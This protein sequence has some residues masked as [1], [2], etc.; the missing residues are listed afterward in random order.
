[1]TVIDR[2]GFD[3]TECIRHR[4]VLPAR[5]GEPV[6]W[7]DFVTSQIAAAFSGITAPWRHQAEAAELAHA[8]IPVIVATGTASGKSLAYLLPAL[9]SIE[10]GSHAPDGRGA[11]VL[12][13]APTK[14]LAHDQ[15]RTLEELKAAGL[16]WLRAATYDGDTPE[17]ERSWVREHANFVLSNPDLVHHSML[18]SRAWTPF[19]RRL[20]TIV[21]D[22]AHAYRGVFGAHV[23]LVL[24]RL[25][26]ACAAVGSSPVVV[27]ASATTG[28]PVDHLARLLGCASDQVRAI[29]DDASPRP[30]REIVLWQPPDRADGTRRSANAEAA[31]LLADCVIAGAPAL[32]FVRSR[33]G[34]EAV[35]QSAADHVGEVD[36]SLIDRIAAYRGGY[37][38]EE[39]RALEARLR[40][41]DVLGMAATSALEL[42]I[43][44]SGLDA[45]ITAGWPGTRASLWQQFGRAGR[46]G[47]AAAA[48]LVA[49]DDP[50]DAFLMNHPDTVFSGA[51]RTVFDPENPYVL[52]PHLCAAAAEQPITDED[53][54]QWFGASAPGVLAE[55]GERGMLR[56]RPTGWY[57]TRPERASS[58]ADLRGSSGAVV[59]IVEADT[60]RLLG[61]VDAAASHAT[62]HEGAIYVHMGAQYRVIALDLDDAVALVEPADVDYM[63]SAQEASD[64]AIVERRESE[65]WGDATLALGTVDVTSQVVSFQR[66]RIL[67]GGLL[68]TTP[69]DLP[70]R[71]LRT[72][73]I[74]W[75][76][77]TPL[78]PVV[79]DL[80]GAAH[81]AEHA[82]IG[83]LPLIATC[84][85]WDIGGVS[86]ALHPD[87]GQL[88]VFVHD[89]MPGGAGFAEAGYRAARTWLTDTRALIA[90]C[91]CAD[92][93]PACVQSP[94]C[95]NGN[96]PLDKAGA[97]ALLDALLAQAPESD[98]AGSPARAT[99]VM[100]G[101]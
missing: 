38:P 100:D 27:A 74:W 40:S 66:R 23:A 55:L 16:S 62:V 44:V 31:E 2:M 12:Y 56:R 3:R 43:D 76:L 42:G 47:R 36:A 10:A 29:T 39:R 30:E 101:A 54:R 26:R 80:G 72:T 41:G 70:A 77:P 21:I 52:A 65:A 93:C 81:A 94:K 78:L 14:A 11:T 59:R 25:R 34:A 35:A 84:D 9:A 37:L 45:V 83:L 67:T 1:M 24:R 99:P 58:L 22:E 75:T 85:R 92:G 8:G 28:D 86:T 96:E 15:L 82:S 90:T 63:T 48:V 60:G 20:T 89:G 6:P 53:A 51:E 87:T 79:D 7:P 71:T 57:W 64:I 91:T 49:R 4:R 46:A 32:A 98:E 17:D 18:G 19:L 88:T 68:D 97:V 61:T 5:S 69:L 95:G 33:R 50:L 13:L 73:A